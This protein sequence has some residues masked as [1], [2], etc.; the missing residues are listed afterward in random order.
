M[1]SLPLSLVGDGA[2]GALRRRGRP[3]VPVAR[4]G[5][6]DRRRCPRWPS[7][8]SSSSPGTRA[9]TGA[10]GTSRRWPPPPTRRPGPRP[11]ASPVGTGGDDVAIIV[12]Q[13]HRGHQP[14]GLPAAPRAPTT[15]SSPP[16]PSTTPTCCRG[17]GP[18]PAAASSSAGPT[19]PSPSTTSIAALDDGARPALLAITGATN[20]TGWLPPDRRHHRR[21]P[22]PRRARCWSTPPS[23]PP[24]A[25][26]RPTADFIA[27][28]GHKMYAPFGAGVLIGPRSTFTEGDPFLAGGGAVDLVDLD[29]VVWTDPPEREE[30]G[31]PNVIGA[32]ALGA[33]IDGLE[34]H[35]LGRRS[36]PTRTSWPRRLRRGLAAIDGVRLLGPAARRAHPRRGDLRGRRTCP[37]RWWR[38]G[39]RP[40]SASACATAASA[41]TRT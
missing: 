28:S 16:W 41:P 10:P 14:P 17:P 19:A 2:R 32:V 20:V 37:T 7:G 11:C 35:R 4:L 1:T 12:P 39:S 30:A 24:T 21:G 31:S 9:C 6:V 5:R 34:T 3:A 8:W 25:R 36:S 40:S 15:W 22:R 18:V 26:C 38:P 23:S 33:A 27:W 13:H 29:E